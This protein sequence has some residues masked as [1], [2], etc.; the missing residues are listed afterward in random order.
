MDFQFSDLIRAD[1]LLRRVIATYHTTG[2]F[3]DIYGS[4]LYLN[5]G[6]EK[7]VSIV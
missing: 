7:L 5:G 2:M 3:Y 4:T 6:R 1:T